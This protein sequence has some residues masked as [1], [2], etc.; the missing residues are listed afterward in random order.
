MIKIFISNRIKNYL[1]KKQKSNLSCMKRNLYRIFTLILLFSTIL[2]SSP[3]LRQIFI[4][5]NVKQPKI[6]ENWVMGRILIDEYDSGYTWSKTA[7]ENDWCNGSGTWADPYI[8]ENVTINCNSGFALAI[9]DSNAYFIIRNSQFNYL[10]TELGRGS[11]ILFTNNGRIINCTFSNSYYYGIDLV[12]SDNITF[13]GNTFSNNGFCGIT[14][15]SGC[16]YNTFSNNIIEGNSKAGILLGP[17]S[18]GNVISNNEISGNFGH[19]ISLEQNCNNNT[20]TGNKIKENSQ[21]GIYINSFSKIANYN[22]ISRNSISLNN[23]YGIYIYANFGE[24]NYNYI[25]GNNITQNLIYGVYLNKFGNP[26][27]CQNNIIIENLFTDNYP[28]DNGYNNFWNNSQTGNYYSDYSYRDLDD[29]GIGD[30]PYN[31]TGSANSVDHL[32]IWDDGIESAPYFLNQPGDFSMTEEDEN[33]N[34]TWTP[35]DINGNYNSFEILQDGVQILS[36]V[37]NGSQIIYT[38]LFN[39]EPK[40]YNFTC[41]VSD[42]DSLENSSTVIVSILN[43][44]FPPNIIIITPTPF[45]L[46]GNKTI[47]FEIHIEDPNLNST[48]YSLNGGFNYTFI[49]TSETISQTAWNLCGNGTVLITFYANDT[50]GNLGS[51]NIIV[52]KETSSPQISIISPIHFQLCGSLA[53]K[54]QLSI[55]ELNLDSTWYSLNGGNNHT[56]SDL[57]AT[58]DQATWNTFGNGSV[59]V[60]FYAN[61]TVGNEAY[62]EVIVRKDII[63]PLITII[64]PQPNGLFGND[65]IDFEISIDEPHLNS[66]WYSLNGGQEYLFTGLVGIINQGAWDTCGNNT[67]TIRFFAND[68]LGNIDFSEVTVR[69]DSHNPIIII[70][71]PQSNELFGNESIDFELSINDAHLNTTW[72]SVNGGPNIIFTGFVGSIQQNLWNSCENGTVT[73]MFF[74]NDTLGNHVVEEVNVRK[75]SLIPIINVIYPQPYELFGNESIGFELSIDEPHLNSTWYSLNGGPE[76]IFTG[77]IGM[78][79]QGAWDACGN[80]TVI[81]KFYANDSLGN[82]AFS[83]VIVRKETR[84]PQILNL[85]PTAYQLYGSLAPNYELSIDEPLLDSTWYSLNGGPNIFFTGLV[86]TINQSAWDACGNGTVIIRFNAN[87][88]AG[89]VAYVDVMVHK[90]II[91][92]SITIISPSPNEI[93]GVGTLDYELSIDEPNIDSTWYSL[94]GGPEYLF[95]GSIG[96]ID[97]GAWDACGNGTVNIIFY[98]NDSLGNFAFEEVIVRKD[99][100]DPLITILNPS[101]LELFGNDTIDF[102]LSIDEQNIDSTWYSLNGGVEYLFVG[103]IG[104]IEQGAWDA[105]GNGTVEIRFYAN[106]TAG[107]IAFST[108]TIRKDTSF[109]QMLIVSPGP[110]Q[111]FGSVAPDFEISIDEPQLRSTWYSLNGGPNIFFTGLVGTINQI[112]WD[113]CGNGT[114][115]IE[116]FANNS[117]GN[118]AYVDLIVYKDIINPN[119]IIISP[120]SNEIFGVGT[121]DFELLINEPN[122]ESTWYSLNGGPN[123]IFTGLIDTIDQGLWNTCGNGT[124]T[125]KFYAND[126]LGNSAFEEVVVRKDIIDP[127]IIIINPLQMELVSNDT[128]DFEL[129]IDEPNIDST[130]YSLNGGSE[131]LFTSL[132]GIIDQGAWNAC[133]NGTVEIRFYA[134]DTTGNVAFSTITVRKD[135]YLPKLIINL[136]TIN[137]ICGLIAPSFDLSILGS[138]IDT[139]WHLLNG[140]FKQIFT[141]TVQRIDQEAW[142]SFGEGYIVIQFYANNSAGNIEMEEVW[143]KKITALLDKNAYAIIIGI[144]NYPGYSN[145]LSYCDDDAIAVYN[146]LINDF[147]FKSEN[148]IYLQDSSATKANI[149]NA[150][151]SIASVINP[152]DI[153]FFYYSGHGGGNTETIGPFYSSINSPHPYPNNYD[154]IWNIDFPDAAAIRVHFSQIDIEYGYD[155]LLLGDTDISDGWYYQEFT[156]SMSNVWSDWIPL[157]NDNKIYLRLI[158]DSIVTR[159]GFQIDRYEVILYDGTHYLVSYDSLPDN[160]SNYYLDTLLDLK[161][162]SLNCDEKYVVLDSCN[163]GGFIPEVQEIGRYMMTACKGS[164]TS[165]ESGSLQHGVFTYYLLD[166]LEKA[167]DQNFDGVISL[168]ESYSYI[169]SKTTSYSGIYG[170]GYRYHPQQYD[171][172]GGQSVLQTSI[173]SFSYNLVGNRLYYSFYLYGTGQLDTLNITLCSISPETTTKTVEIKNLMISYTGFGFYSDFIELDENYNV[174]SFELLCEVLGNE[175]ITLKISYGDTD[176]DGL[177]DVMEILNGLDPTK[178]DTDNDGLSDYE[179]FHGPTDP[180]NSDTDND[181][182]EDYDEIYVYHTDPIEADSDSDNLLDGEEVNIYNT[183]PLEPDCDSDGLLDGNEINIHFTDPLNNDTDFDELSDGDEILI[184][185]TNPI[186]N[187]T[188]SDNLFDA[189]EVFIYFTNPLLNDT[190]YDGLSDYDE[191]FIYNTNPLEEDTDSDGLSDYDELNIHT[192]NPL[193]PDTDSDTI[194]DG[195]E[196]NNLLDPFTNDTALDPDNDLLT[197][198]EE[199]QF[200]TQ[201]FNNDTDSD[202]LLDGE[203]V[204]NYNT[205]PLQ[206]DT[207]SDGLLD[208]EEVNTYNTDPLQEDTDSDGLLDGEEVN[209]YN[210]DPLSRDT[211]SDTMPDKWEIDNLL[212]PLV[213]DTTLDPDNDLLMNVLEYQHGTNPQDP[214][215]DNDNWTD[216][217]E[218]LVYDTDPLDPDDHPNPRQE[219]AI[220]GYSFGFV[221][222]ITAVVMSIW[223]IRHKKKLSKR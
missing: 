178:N 25:I 185:N 55:D 18:T 205:E 188:D 159:W 65:T 144:S 169:Y 153:F 183:D 200:N 100:I 56:F 214:D 5:N 112:A 148:I 213:N 20:I 111:L 105:C 30:T 62:E 24:T 201:P 11:I 29:D 161:L 151:N 61:N 177:T 2:C 109:P 125:I 165:T 146:M 48:W 187:D 38:E 49:G 220:P 86:G 142:K 194:P 37:W 195:W 158:T 3:L 68:S 15:E 78:I 26:S 16:K 196:V 136:P 222:F 44:I 113:V 102:E 190:D 157:L 27:Y 126:S 14:L 108:I 87:N 156:G 34:I 82:T 118:V 84:F 57:N 17:G 41:I 150:F 19:G 73:I 36:D 134:N 162:D 204:N 58:I 197:N 107:N 23:N 63:N 218:V 40:V 123:H 189:E 166:S 206:E 53:P 9:V 217:D 121:L 168:E 96:M 51:N 164:Q 210:T 124:V 64:T 192:T 12:D 147:N 81:I 170:S 208:G 21:S 202:G 203:E 1:S 167:N 152:Q 132:I 115:I 143:V 191:I 88:S 99:M 76:Y 59:T 137:Q 116:F 172:I 122:L 174:T 131:Y 60:R 212:N 173:G 4:E 117:A 85:E 114:V 22:N 89:N 110:D 160:P 184:Y 35:I 180:L 42:T 223:I 163:S 104:M 97:Q 80:S 103:T 130:W 46:Y 95:T 33:K 155:Y 6:S 93:F 106:D 133:G 211:D 154:R 215:T 69:K 52:R 31:I 7:T 139:T 207:D 79:D 138:D 176:G 70:L 74:A 72:Y 66:T 71:S 127:L 216:G 47:N 91:N 186:N 13:S 145:D 83:E 128:I 140:S 28:V 43:D 39:L 98:A 141:G 135:I 54:F 92:P 209:T 119:I 50:F 171:G 149:N 198:L 10:G 181:G 8:I 193:N 45:H 175:L 219:Q 101:Q 221:I 67:V 32:P 179:E 199:Y 129:S 182:L 120:S 77:L 75:D 90:D 94:N